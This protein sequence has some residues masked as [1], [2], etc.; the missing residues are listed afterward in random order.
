[1]QNHAKSPV[2][3]VMSA[4]QVKTMP[5]LVF[6][7]VYDKRENNEQNMTAT[8]GWPERDVRMKNLGAFPAAARPSVN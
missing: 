7:I 3:A 1:M 5:E 2:V 6:T 8:Y 4:N